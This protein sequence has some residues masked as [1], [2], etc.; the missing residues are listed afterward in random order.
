[1]YLFFKVRQS[2][3]TLIAMAVAL[4]GIFLLTFGNGVGMFR[5]QG[6][7][8]VLL[9]ALAYA[10]YMVM[11]KVTSLRNLPAMT[12]TF[13]VVCCGMIIFLAALNGGTAL[14]GLPDL[15]SVGCALGLAVF[16]SF[17]A[18]LFM[19][20]A[21]RYIGPSQTA[22]LGSLEPIT[23]LVIGV[24]VFHE[25]LNFQ[26]LG[27]IVMILGAVTLVVIGSGPTGLPGKENRNL[28]DGHSGDS[29][30]GT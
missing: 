5:F 21:I 9:S 3:S 15:F 30:T 16:P 8:F 26:Q 17:C 29:A 2:V 27:A 4:A 23:A 18:F 25:T 13:Y 11:V 28:P 24:L 14:Q 20:V 6:L 1:M 19:A 10:I 22:I 7:L 12:L